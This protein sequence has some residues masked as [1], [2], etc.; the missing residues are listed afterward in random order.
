[1]LLTIRKDGSQNFDNSL[2]VEVSK[3]S[4][5]VKVTTPTDFIIQFKLNDGSFINW[6]YRDIDER[7]FDFEILLSK[8]YFKFQI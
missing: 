5:M 4:K 8:E 3:I 1:M 6:E 7:N 2:D